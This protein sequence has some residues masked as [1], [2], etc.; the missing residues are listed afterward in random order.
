MT[1]SSSRPAKKPKL[2]EDRIWALRSNLPDFQTLTREQFLD[3]FPAHSRNYIEYIT[4]CALMINIQKPYRRLQTRYF[5]VRWPH[6]DSARSLDR[7]W[8]LTHGKGQ[9]WREKG[10][11]AR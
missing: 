3:G 1:D 5:E 4:Y 11:L 10:Y 6:A 2:E 9:E 8:T 7:K